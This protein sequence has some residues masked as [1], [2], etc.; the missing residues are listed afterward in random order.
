MAQLRTHV[1]QTTM[2]AQCRAC[3][4]AFVTDFAAWGFAISL[5][6][7][8]ET[9]RGVY[10]RSRLGKGRSETT[11]VRAGASARASLTVRPAAPPWRR[12]TLGM[13]EYGFATPV[14]GQTNER[15]SCVWKAVRKPDRSCCHVGCL[16]VR[17]PKQA[18]ACWTVVN[19][20]QPYDKESCTVLAAHRFSTVNT[21]TD[22]SGTPNMSTPGSDFVTGV[23][24]TWDT[25]S[26][27]PCCYPQTQPAQ[28]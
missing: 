27:P 9:Y 2:V 14:F 26:F 20:P 18:D 15:P 7:V 10:L 11:L 24:Q 6:S 1:P 19:L 22:W 3:R 21:A 23:A 13:V 12:V 4:A 17:P 5:A 25:T 8:A 28:G 16:I